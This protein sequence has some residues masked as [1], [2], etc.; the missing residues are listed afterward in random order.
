MDL[1]SACK[2]TKVLEASISSS[3]HN[4]ELQ[5]H[6]SK[7]NILSPTKNE[8]STFFQHLFKVHSQ[9]AILLLP[10]DSHKILV[11]LKDDMPGN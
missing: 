8:Q 9:S 11:Q 4:P 7:D 1:T 6:I 10:Q 3:N 5:E 2:K